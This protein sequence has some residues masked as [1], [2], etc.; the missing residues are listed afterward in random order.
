MINRQRKAAGVQH[1]VS[2]TEASGA[3]TTRLQTRPVDLVMSENPYGAG[4]I[5]SLTPKASI[6]AVQKHTNSSLLVNSRNSITA[7]TS[8]QN[9][10]ASFNLQT[11]DNKEEKKQSLQQRQQNH[12]YTVRAEA[13]DLAI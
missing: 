5:T 1:D 12:Q 7:A 11:S 10:S 4:R 9:K 3:E 13:Q 6:G 2:Q 8:N